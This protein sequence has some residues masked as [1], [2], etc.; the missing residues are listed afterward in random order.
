MKVKSSSENDKMH[1]LVVEGG[2][3]R[4]IFS[5][6][7][8]DEFMAH[9]HYPFGMC[10]GV[11]AGATN[12]AAYLCR[13]P[14]RNY[15]VITDYSCRKEFISL[16]RFV[17]G[18]HWLDLDWLWHITIREYRLDLA[19]YQTQSIPLFLVTTDIETGLPHYI[20]PDANEL[21]QALKASCAVPLAYRN[22]PELRGIAM[23]D[24]GL[25]DSIP[26]LEA[27]NQGAREI[28]V[29]L[30][31]PLGYRKSSRK[32]NWLTRRL[33]GM[34]PGLLEAVTRRAER[35]NRALDFIENPPA[36]CTVNV[37]A[38]PPHFA[39]GR[40]T[41]HRGKLDAGY[42]MGREAARAALLSNRAFRQ[43]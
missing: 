32:Q 28:T 34:R 26:V 6:G 40:T 18:G 24:G 7:A 8:L 14:G 31:R 37:L 38:P 17:R 27:Y 25:A 16:T 29:M 20:R 2:A 23:T 13:Q 10:F 41:T 21:E 36:D 9:D 11:S 30:S 1:A 12:L 19:T 42:Q 4:G 39:V 33:F 35:Y 15:K 43:T 3:M 5:C 22:Y